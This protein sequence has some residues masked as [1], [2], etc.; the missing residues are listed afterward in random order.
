MKIRS[1][2]IAV[3]AALMLLG[4][5]PSAA[6][7]S[8]GPAVQRDGGR[9]LIV[10][11]PRL[12][13][14]A[15][16]E[17]RP[18][19]MMTLFERASVASMSVRTASSTTRPADA[20]LTIGAGNRMAVPA[21]LPSGEVLDRNETMWDRNPT[22]AFQRTTGFT[23]DKPIVSINK[24]QLDR[25]NDQEYFF[26]ARAGSLASSLN[27][28]DR[29][30]AVIG[31]ADVALLDSYRRQVGLAAMNLDGQV[32]DGMVDRSLLRANPELPFG[33]EID[34]AVH[35]AAFER[36]WAE[37]DVVLA[38][39]SDLERAE[40]AREVSTES[41]GDAQYERALLS[42]DALLASMM[43]HVDLERDTVIVVSGV[44]PLEQLELTVFAVAGP[45]FEP[46]WA[47]S[48][49]TRRDRF[50]TLTD[51]APSI[52]SHYDL[53]TPSGMND[54]RI[55]SVAS[56]DAL[57]ARME[58][59][60]D[61]SERAVVRD[62]TF[63]PVSV[64]F[65]VA[66][67]L[68]IVAA[69]SCL[70]W[71]PRLNRFIWAATVVQL[72]FLPATYLLGVFG[73]T[74]VSSLVLG[75]VLGT[76]ALAA[77]ASLF[78]SVDTH[79]PALALVALL[80]S[81]LAIDIATGGRLQL[82]TIFGYSPI[83]AGR[84]AGFGN[85]AYS[86]F[87]ITAL[88]LA[89]AFADRRAPD[90]RGRATVATVAAIAVWTGLALVLDGHPSMGSDVGGVLSIVPAA[91]V[92]ILLLRKIRIDAKLVVGIGVATVAVLAGFAALDLSRP[93]ENQTHLGRF[94]SDL[95]DGGAGTI[96]QRKIAANLRVLTSVWAW[97]IPA[98]L[99]YFCY[100]IWRPN[101][102]FA[103]LG[104]RHPSYRAFGV[105]ALTLGVMSMAVN[106]S[107]VSLPAIMVAI[108]S[109]YTINLVMDMERSTAEGGRLNG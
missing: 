47:R 36:L 52:L 107:G 31:N 18:P 103:R 2:L 1:L 82:N 30:M 66:L 69:M 11:A 12:T 99:G 106:D 79:L 108:V 34:P 102:T 4:G 73:F 38:E 6:S 25:F 44:A 63:G 8:T 28:G 65:V 50:V 88:I 71:F 90:E 84:F 41:Q 7:A 58:T 14:T 105:G 22:E 95:V 62:R 74:T 9:V 86:M 59:L 70:A 26:D 49:T 75:L 55:T 16:D 92:F 109:A 48:S 35:A 19:T 42:S 45:G 89:A 81:V 51:I 33:I 46:G 98:S 94:A 85:Q 37:N 5:L 104:E 32:D 64:V 76:A 20:Y 97:V 3:T 24:P 93:A 78:R 83:V 43:R 21:T 54:T 17:V 87:A 15:V 60:I 13:W 56:S 91:T 61:D 100:I 27:D 72:A 53:E 77:V 29:T 10:S 40:E 96:I 101:R 68:T 80:W 57:D 67:V 23:A 39:L